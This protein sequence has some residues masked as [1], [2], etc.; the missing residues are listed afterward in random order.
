M[1][2]QT[3]RRPAGE[4]GK[5][6]ITVNADDRKMMRRMVADYMQS[7]GCSCCQNHD[8]HAKHKA[9][10]AKILNVKK[11]SDGS[12]YDFTRYATKPIK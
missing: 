6:E 3:T 1:R 9:A 5:G 11:Y 7:E 12:G 2:A 10:L 8:E 4:T